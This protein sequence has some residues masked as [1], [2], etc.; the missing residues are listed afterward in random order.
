MSPFVF[1]FGNYPF[2]KFHQ[3]LKWDNK[4]NKNMV[5]NS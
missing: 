2:K 1:L 4:P 5:N 3:Q